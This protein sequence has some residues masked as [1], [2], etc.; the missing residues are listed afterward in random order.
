MGRSSISNSIL[1]GAN[2]RLPCGWCNFVKWDASGVRAVAV[3]YALRIVN[4]T[5]VVLW[6]DQICI[7]QSDLDE[8]SHQVFRENDNCNAEYRQLPI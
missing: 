6:A 4:D 8:R 7:N 2:V 5:E 1:T 3:F